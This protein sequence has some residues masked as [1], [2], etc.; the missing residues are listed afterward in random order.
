MKRP[1]SHF[2]LKV[3]NFDPTFNLWIFS[4]V[5]HQ[6]DDKYEDRASLFCP[7]F[8]FCIWNIDVCAGNGFVVKALKGKMKITLF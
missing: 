1:D 2:S 8:W 7:A 6:T 5:F 4:D 3:L